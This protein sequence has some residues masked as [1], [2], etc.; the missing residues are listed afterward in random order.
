[1]WAISAALLRV[2][3]PPKTSRFQRRIVSQNRSSQI[4]Y[5]AHLRRSQLPIERL[6]FLWIFFGEYV[7]AEVPDLGIPL[8]VD[9]VRVLGLFRDNIPVPQR[10][11][12][13]VGILV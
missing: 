6:C 2:G 3:G 12:V 11:Q 4:S 10:A 8:R 9:D 13:S 1:M 5:T 7:N